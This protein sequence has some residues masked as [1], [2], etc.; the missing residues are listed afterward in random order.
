MNRKAETVFPENTQ[1]IEVSNLRND[2]TNELIT[3]DDSP[4]IKGWLQD[5]KGVDIPGQDQPIEFEHYDGIWLGVLEHTL[6]IGSMKKGILRVII[7]I[8]ESIVG[9]FKIPVEF[10]DRRYL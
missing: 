3:I 5:T 8:G 7:T 1:V 2:I 10:K 4:V 9:D 6:E